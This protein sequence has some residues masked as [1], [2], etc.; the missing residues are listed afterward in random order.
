MRYP[1][2][3][4]KFLS[5]YF[6]W[7]SPD[8]H[9]LLKFPFF[10]LFSGLYLLDIGDIFYL[11]ICR[12]IHQMILERIFGVTRYYTYFFEINY[13]NK[14]KKEFPEEF[15]KKIPIDFPQYSQVF[16]NYFQRILKGFLKN[17]QINSYRFPKEFP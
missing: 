4:L 16:P 14:F 15:S 1:V 9:N 6:S 10:L 11:Y 12:G 7:N 8:E 2:V 5:V 13:Q 3:F 17:F